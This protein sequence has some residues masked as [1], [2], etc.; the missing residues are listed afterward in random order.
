MKIIFIFLLSLSLTINTFS[1][2]VSISP[3]VNIRNDNSFEVISINNI[4]IV[5]RYNNN[6]FILNIFDQN[7]SG[8]SEKKIFLEK[9]NSEIVSTSVNDKNFIIFYSINYK[10]DESVKAIKINENGEKKDSADLFTPSSNIDSY[11]FKNTE[12]EDKSKTLLFRSINSTEMDFIVF[13]N[14]KFRKL[15]SKR[16]KF[17]D[18]K[19]N[20]E[21][22]KISISNDGKVFM[23]F[24]KTPGIFNKYTNKMIVGSIDPTDQNFRKKELD[25]EFYFDNFK[26]FFDNINK[27]LLIAGT[28]NKLFQNKSEGYFTIKFNSEL[29]LI[30]VKNNSFNKS[31]LDTYYKTM[32]LKTYINNLKVKDI[33]PRNDG[34]FVLLLEKVEIITRQSNNDF[35]MRYPSYVESTDN[36]YGEIILISIHETG[37]EFWSKIITKNQISS[38]D[39]GVYSSFGVL[40][41][42][43]RMNIIFNDE[44]KDETQVI[45]YNINP[46]GNIGRISLF[47]TELYD[48]K[49][50]LR[51][52][53]QLSNRNLLIPSYNK[54]KLKLVLLELENN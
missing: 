31:L 49:L 41:T 8:Y 53:L 43:G 39:Q 11:D 38:N 19:T 44:I 4:P 16:I 27:H 3:P 47:N 23:L 5:F 24:Q 17:K 40:K 52:S 35:R 6:D 20:T 32:K 25:I 18:I 26:I 10:G 2:K 14:I 46:I 28:R 22:R 37:E 12:S 42:P 50:M 21:F 48:L 30:F 1:Q 54:D 13:D 9:R 15:Y 51:E 33:F 7:L 45:M 36:I 29:E 34:G